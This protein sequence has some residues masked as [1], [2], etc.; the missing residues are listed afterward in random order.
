MNA[1]GQAYKVSKLIEVIPEQ[2]EKK[3][4]PKEE[5]KQADLLEP[6]DRMH[7]LIDLKES[8]IQQV[9]NNCDSVSGDQSTAR[10]ICD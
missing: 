1:I 9:G 4:A 6:S 8:Q 7:L 2:T 5:S 3:T 10:R